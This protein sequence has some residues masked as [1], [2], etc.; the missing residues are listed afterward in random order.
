[1][2]GQRKTYLGEVNDH[3]WEVGD[4]HECAEGG[5][6][7]LAWAGADYIIKQFHFHSPSEH[8]VDGKHFAMEAHFVFVTEAGGTGPAIGTREEL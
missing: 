4:S 1:L 6:L 3:T 2:E 8:T 7:K 5:K